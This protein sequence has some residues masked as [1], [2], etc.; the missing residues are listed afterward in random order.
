MSTVE[1]IKGGARTMG[2]QGKLAADC[3][4][5]DWKSCVSL[6]VG[7]DI[8]ACLAGDVDA[9]A[10][11]AL[12]EGAKA[13]CV[14]YLNSHGAAK[15]TPICGP[16]AS[17][18]VDYA[19]P[20][21]K[22][23]F[24]ES[25]NPLNIVTGFGAFFL[26]LIG[27]DIGGAVSDF[28]FGHTSFDAN[29]TVSFL[30][31]GGKFTGDKYN[32]IYYPP[33]PPLVVQWQKV[34]LALQTAWNKSRA[35][36]G[37][38]PSPVRIHVDRLVPTNP[39]KRNTLHIPFN[40]KDKSEGSFGIKTPEIEEPEYMVG[41][42]AC[43]YHWLYSYNEGWGKDFSCL[44]TGPHVTGGAWVSTS[45][46]AGRVEDGI[47]WH[48]NTDQI[49]NNTWVG[50]GPF[51]LLLSGWPD[52]CD[53]TCNALFAQCVGQCWKHRLD[54]LGAAL[55]DIVTIMAAQLIDDLAEKEGEAYILDMAKSA[56]LMNDK[57]GLEPKDEGVGIGTVLVVGGALA[58]AGWLT[59][60][61]WL[62]DYL[63]E[64]KAS[65]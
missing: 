58:G 47:F 8:N 17:L 48:T 65:R 38:D 54:A 12:K 25:V 57:A 51:G 35:D 32:P 63:A 56:R 10:K 55:P 34:L 43:L 37:L 15:A 44:Q 13:G 9:C 64:L 20:M 59:W 7:Y 42:E 24:I 11:K 21:A 4:S 36:M 6:S 53:S 22:E 2:G 49:N 5:G 46:L 40:E 27:L 30:W 26:D 28:L 29:G 23:L 52:N 41:P 3:A 39:A 1:K 19:Y 16:V 31:R 50:Q 14:A 33:V 45:T 60:K 61:Y 62:K 18:V